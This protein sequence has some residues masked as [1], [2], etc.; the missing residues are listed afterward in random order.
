MRV[1]ANSVSYMVCGSYYSMS[2]IIGI[3]RKRE[4]R[5][6]EVL[7]LLD[8]QRENVENAGPVNKRRAKGS[9]RNNPQST[10]ARLIYRKTLA[11]V[12]C[13]YPAG[14]AIVSI[15]PTVVFDLLK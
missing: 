1:S 15:S 3:M 4:E 2:R 13:E 14:R 11:A 8:E 7:I 5:R 10:A 9:R 12:A 6:V